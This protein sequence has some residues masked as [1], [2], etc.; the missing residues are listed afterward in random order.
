ML[1]EKSSR[2]KVNVFK[3]T[4]ELLGK[5]LISLKKYKEILRHA[6]MHPLLINQE[7]ALYLCSATGPAYALVMLVHVVNY[8]HHHS[9]HHHPPTHTL[10][11]FLH[12]PTPLLFS[13]PRANLGPCLLFCAT[14]FLTFLV[15]VPSLP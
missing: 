12:P 13:F 6:E 8:Q 1:K 15:L 3:P 11:L 4:T 2:P 7:E 10:F 5:K 9:P 14:L